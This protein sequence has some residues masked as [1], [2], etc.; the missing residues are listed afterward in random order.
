MKVSADNKGLVIV[1]D[2]ATNTEKGRLVGH[3]SDVRS[4]AIS[5]D[6]KLAVSADMEVDE[7]PTIRVWDLETNKEKSALKGHS[8]KK[9]GTAVRVLFS[10]CGTFLMSCSDCQLMHWDLETGEST[11]M[12]GHE[13]YVNHIAIT[14]DGTQVVSTSGDETICLWKLA[15]KASSERQPA[16]L[17]EPGA[18]IA[19][20]NCGKFAA[21]VNYGTKSSF[22]HDHN[23]HKK[24]CKIWDLTCKD[25][26]SFKE[27][28]TAKRSGC[29]I[30]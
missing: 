12:S 2:M 27:V 16:Q 28:R 22:C 17:G 24:T 4:V 7:E 25:D 14:P 8:K 1:W 19:I 13:K 15:N 3:T 6:N 18:A 10:P 26:G 30:C 29:V 11:A 21:T 5:P 9:L 20:S 23:K